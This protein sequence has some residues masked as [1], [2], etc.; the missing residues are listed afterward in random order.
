MRKKILILIGTRPEAIKLIPVYLELRKDNRNDVKILSSGQH[1]ELLNQV[2]DFFNHKP[3]IQINLSRKNKNLA[4]LTSEILSKLYNQLI[5]LKPDLLIVQ[6]DTTSA[7]C[8]AM[9]AY[10]L[11]IKTA[12]VEAGLRTQNKYD[13]FP[14]ELNRVL[15][16]RMVDLHFAPTKS[17]YDNL[18]KEGIR[19]VYCVG[20]TSIDAINIGLDLVNQHNSWYLKKFGG[21]LNENK[22]NI[23]ITCHRRESI[24][25]GLQ[26]IFTAIKVLV[27]EYSEF[28]FIFPVHLNPDIK[29][30]AHKQLGGIRKLNL[31][32][33][34]TYGEMIFLISNSYLILTDSG[35]LQ[36]EAPSLNKPVVVLRNRTERTEGLEVGCATLAGTETAG[37]VNTVSYILDNRE[38]YNK[39]ASVEN[40]YGDGTT[41]KQIRKIINDLIH[42]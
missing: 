19:N 29:D 25:I 34:V 15:I 38:K 2:F 10:Y 14:E 6:G 32:D 7:F 21:I 40:P 22:K 26:K 28:S 8:A 41:A 3:D 24:G 31:I 39:M 23:L 30:I 4:D 35:G 11:K 37:I 20:N 17:S 18:L 36:E 1:N 12:H 16:S 33:P 13:P 27:H 42:D 5:E 9:A